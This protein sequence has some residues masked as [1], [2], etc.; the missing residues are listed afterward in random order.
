[1]KIKHVQLRNFN[2]SDVRNFY[3]NKNIEVKWHQ[4]KQLKS[5]NETHA[6]FIGDTKS[7]INN[8]LAVLNNNIMSDRL[9][10]VRGIPKYRTIKTT[11]ERKPEMKEEIKEIF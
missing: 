11:V 6:S 5:N 8:Q 3:P 9:R 10:T 4:D 2:L 7:D 1:M